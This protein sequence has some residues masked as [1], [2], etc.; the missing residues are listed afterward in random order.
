MLNE[1]D[2][3][4]TVQLQGIA[5]NDLPSSGQIVLKVTSSDTMLDFL[6]L[7]SSRVTSVLLLL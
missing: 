3:D 7:Q 2:K 5:A 6:Y 1:L 4:I